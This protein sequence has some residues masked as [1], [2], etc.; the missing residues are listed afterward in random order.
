MQTLARVMDRPPELT[1]P[2][3]ACKLGVTGRHCHAY[4]GEILSC[5]M[6]REDVPNLTKGLRLAYAL[7]HRKRMFS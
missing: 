6:S 5:G 1:V 4:P 3:L 2:P 7:P